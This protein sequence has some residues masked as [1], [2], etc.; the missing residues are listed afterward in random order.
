[1]VESHDPL[2]NT[3][4]ALGFSDP[5]PVG[6]HSI[7]YTY[8]SGLGEDIETGDN[9]VSCVQIERFDKKEQ[10]AKQSRKIW[11]EMSQD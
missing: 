9:F 8:R 4:F 2:A 11:K 6:L 7:V 1:M 3:R 5:S 10:K